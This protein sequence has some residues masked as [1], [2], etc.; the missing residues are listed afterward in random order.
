MAA[1]DFKI[2]DIFLDEITGKRVNP[3]GSTKNLR[4]LPLL[5]NQDKFIFHFRTYEGGII[6][7]P[8]K[9][10]SKL[11][12]FIKE[13]RGL[14][15]ELVAS[16]D[17]DF[18]STHWDASDAYALHTTLSSV[19]GTFA[20]NNL[21]TG[22]TSAATGRVF[23]HDIANNRLFLKNITGTFV[24]EAL[25]E[26]L[27]AGGSGATA[28][29]GAVALEAFSRSGGT[30]S[31]QV[32][33]NTINLEAVAANRQ[34]LDVVCELVEKF[35][36]KTQRTIAQFDIEIINDLFK[37]DDGTT[38]PKANPSEDFIANLLE[39]ATPQLGGDLDVN[40]KKIVSVS[41]G[42]VELLPNGTGSIILGSGFT[43]TSDGFVALNKN[44]AWHYAVNVKISNVT[45]AGTEIIVKYD[46][47]VYEIGTN[48]SI[49]TGDLKA[50]VAG[51]YLVGQSMNWDDDTGLSTS[52]EI[53]FVHTGSPAV[54]PSSIKYGVANLR[55][56][57]DLNTSSMQMI[58]LNKDDTVHVVFKVSGMAGDDIDIDIGSSF[59]G[60][61]VSIGG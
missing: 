49:A 30:I 1:T 5:L 20:E 35:T 15:T 12:L 32:D 55:S 31:A 8:F 26:T 28:T 34:K 37:A 44:P 10:T 42:D 21:V 41:N 23:F 4:A 6:A 39:D 17:A 50:P 36:D 9:S 27:P 54:F 33:F 46:V 43:H 53:R 18:S 14:D 11:N 48:Y 24:A 2:I 45:G 19:T 3:D 13:R 52:Y 56:G 16:I 40:G 25:T 59:Y 60:Y 57:V 61:L 7:Y 47:K 58:Q 22:G 38:S 29:S 51:L